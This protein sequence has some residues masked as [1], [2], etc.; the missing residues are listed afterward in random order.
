MVAPYF[1][2]P[3]TKHPNPDEAYL[4]KTHVGITDTVYSGGSD[5]TYNLKLANTD[6]SKLPLVS[7]SSNVGY[8][9]TASSCSV[10]VVEDPLRDKE[11]VEP[12]IP[13]LIAISF[14]MLTNNFFG[15]SEKDLTPNG[16]LPSNV[17]YFCGIC[18]SYDKGELST[19]GKT[20]SITLSD[21]REI[22]SGVQCILNAKG[23]SASVGTSTLNRVPD[24]KNLIDCY[25]YWS[26][27]LG[28]NINQNG[29][30]WKK[31]RE[32]IERARVTVFGISFEFV[33]TGS[34]FFDAPSWYRING[35]SMD[36]VSLCQKVAKDGGCDTMFVARKYD[37][38]SAIVEIR[39]VSRKEPNPVKETELDDFLASYD[40]RVVSFTR[41]KEFRN[42]PTSPLVVGG[43][44]SKMYVAYPSAA[45]FPVDLTERYIDF[46]SSIDVRIFGE[47]AGNVGAIMPFWGMSQDG[48]APLIDPF[49]FLDHVIYSRQ[50][51]RERIP[52]V[53]F[54]TDFRTVRSRSHDNVFLDDDGK[55]DLRPFSIPTA[56][57]YNAGVPVA[58]YVRG[59][60]LS[61][62]VLN[63][64]LINKDMFMITY[65]MVFP[66]VAASLRFPRIFNLKAMKDHK[67]AGGRLQAFNPFSRMDYT[68]ISSNL[69]LEL[70]ELHDHLYIMARAYAEAYLGV[71]FMVFLPHSQIMER[72][73]YNRHVDVSGD[74]INKFEVPTNSDAPEIEYT[75]DT[76][77]FWE[78]IPTELDG[79]NQYAKVQNQEGQIVR[80]FMQDDGRFS[81]MAV[82]N[83]LPDGNLS[84][85]ATGNIV[86]MF[87]D[88][89]TSEFAPNT[90][91]ASV[92][93]RAWIAI[94]Q[95]AQLQ[96]RPDI[97]IVSLPNAVGFDIG[98]IIGTDPTPTSSTAF[99]NL[100][101]MMYEWDYSYTD[102][103]GTYS[104]KSIIGDTSTLAGVTAVWSGER[105]HAAFTA[106]LDSEPVLDLDAVIIPLK[107]N[108]VSYGPWYDSWLVAGGKGTTEII[109]D[110]SLVPWNFVPAGQ[111][112]GW[113]T[114]LDNAGKDVRDRAKK[115]FNYIEK[116][117]LKV[118][119]FPVRNL[120]DSFG[121]S[122]NITSVSVGFGI[123]E[124][125]TTYNLS[126]YDAIPGTYRKSE[127]DNLSNVRIRQELQ[128]PAT[129]NKNLTWERNDTKNGVPVGNEY[130]NPFRTG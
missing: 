121:Y 44:K 124:I 11:F 128:R 103:D 71:Q 115:Y 79:Y 86:A 72:I 32:S 75:I 108:Y 66:E 116:A 112:S 42:E 3:D 101:K 58:G 89:P 76:A 29:M 46:P 91:A 92:P 28:A 8:N 95:V 114:K 60:P 70:D 125:V 63:A 113:Q 100:L 84:F 68:P 99:I 90:L 16:F 6:G 57:I 82:M 117:V 62:D 30:E 102:S 23:L 13:S 36:L 39:G 38:T 59:I 73:F 53:K 87:N 49:L 41:G 50:A 43:N 52:L 106:G 33:F 107:S 18:T 123:N 127:Y 85:F 20:I 88:L 119:G 80:R 65:R 126:S 1:N 31:V 98:G 83:R 110:D 10:T 96:R 5:T 61:T 54:E 93:D 64:A 40:G 55:E 48:N 37:E 34:C 129:I 4:S 94:N 25:G 51:I 78:T 45:T 104:F 14:P 24:V 67:D 130:R 118:V 19:S 15:E 81:A 35:D 56:V 21:P 74:L 27:G 17:F 105:R 77:G 69:N 22:L 2:A 7:F 26:H 109:K 122:S 12:T 97:A 120:G 9:S 111:S 47:A